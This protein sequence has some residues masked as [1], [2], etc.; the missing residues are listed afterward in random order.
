MK[1]LRDFYLA[2]LFFMALSVPVVL[3]VLAFFF[4]FLNPFA[5]LALLLLIV[6]LIT[7][8]LLLFATKKILA[9]RRDL[10][11]R[12][13]NGDENPITITIESFCSFKLYLSII[14]ELPSQLQIRDFNVERKIEAFKEIDFKY[15]IRPVRRGEYWFGNI[16]VLS[17]TVL[18]LVMRRTKCG[19][20]KAI[21]CYPSFL[22]L[23]KF[24]LKAVSNRL[25]EA[26]LKS[27]SRMGQS[28]DFESIRNYSRGDDIRTINWKATAR[29]Q[30]LM[31]NQ[32][33]DERSQQ[34]YCL[35]DA[36][37]NMKSPFAGMTLLDYAINASLI[38]SDISILKYDKA[39]LMTFSNKVHHFISASNRKVQMMRIMEHLHSI[40]T[41]FLETSF[42]I[43]ATTLLSKITQR[44]LIVLFTNFESRLSL[45][46][47][48]P[49]LRKIAKNHLL[50]LVY[51]ENTEIDDLLHSSPSNLEDVY[52]K[53]IAEKYNFERR[54]M[55]E[56]FRRN[57]IL[58]LYTPPA[59]LNVNVINKYLEIKARQMI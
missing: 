6:L 29:K 35:I 44:S 57:G 7:D 31:I 3:F 38:L 20:P 32:F 40:E 22:Q 11:V 42:E 34:V 39:G 18:G 14:D 56:E 59:K 23:N 13:S 46:R 41:N 43:M 45:Q 19:E 27:V 51:F 2:P 25:T 24:E 28:F 4:P 47:Q 54:Y 55:M 5:E 53:T 49:F 1:L 37:R 21:A 10:P 16:N 12:L 48:L 26:G 36:G 15:F 30:T 17:A 9:A 8:I 33:Q 58:S 50:L 52:L